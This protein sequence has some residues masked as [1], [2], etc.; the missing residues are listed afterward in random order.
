MKMQAGKFH[1][2]ASNRLSFEIHDADPLQYPEL[3]ATVASQFNLTPVGDLI[4]GL[5]EMFHD[6]TDGSLCIGLDWDNWSGFIVV[7]KSPES[8]SLVESIG[9][10]L[11][12]S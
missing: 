5:D 2:D 11:T 9:A 4:V 8:E 12:N 7:A 6:Y 10:F 1:R 3:A